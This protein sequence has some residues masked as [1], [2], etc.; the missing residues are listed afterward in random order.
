MTRH[1]GRSD[2]EARAFALQIAEKLRDRYGFAHRFEQN[3]LHF[4]RSGAKGRV[5]IAPGRVDVQIQVGALFAPLKGR[6]ARKLSE[7]LD[8]S[9]GAEP[10]RNVDIL[11]RPLK[12]RPPLA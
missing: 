5:T 9:L 12:P 10:A 1:H 4:H 2:A 11:K 7:L 3:V 8:R 6:I